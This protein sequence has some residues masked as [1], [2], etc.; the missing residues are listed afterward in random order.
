METKKFFIACVAMVVMNVVNL[1]AQNQNGFTAALN[2]SFG[3][4]NRYGLELG[5]NY[6]NVNVY[7]EGSFGAYNINNLS[8]KTPGVRVGADYTFAK[9]KKVG[10]F[11][12][13][14]AG[15]TAFL[16]KEKDFKYA[17]IYEAGNINALTVGIKAGVKVNVGKR[18]FVRAAALVNSHDFDRLVG[19]SRTEG[20]HGVYD[21]SA[22]FAVGYRF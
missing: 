15:Y 1:S 7:V 18:M 17:Y 11:A 5:Y 2:T 12:G 20:T 4:E 9:V 6:K 21:V 19:T 3:T 22:N 10:F 16:G 14:Y 8:Y 13:A